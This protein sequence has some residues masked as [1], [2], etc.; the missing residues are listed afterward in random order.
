MWN[1]ISLVQDL[2]SCRRVHFLRRQRLHHGHLLVPFIWCNIMINHA[3]IETCR[4]DAKILGLVGIPQIRHIRRW[5]IN[6][7]LQADKAWRKTP[8]PCDQSST[9]HPARMPGGPSQRQMSFSQPMEERT[10]FIYKASPFHHSLN[11]GGVTLKSQVTR[12][13]ASNLGPNWHFLNLIL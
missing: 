12:L 6:P 2:N 1:A 4:A 5:P 8:R 11:E 3:Q 13:Y 10:H 7:T 9:T